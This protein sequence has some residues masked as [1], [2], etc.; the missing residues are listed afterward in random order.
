MTNSIPTFSKEQY[1]DNTVNFFKPFNVNISGTSASGTGS[2]L[3]QQ[4]GIDVQTI[5]E[6]T[7]QEGLHTNPEIN[8]LIDT[9]HDSSKYFNIFS[10]KSFGT[11]SL[12]PKNFSYENMIKLIKNDRS[13]PNNAKTFAEMSPLGAIVGGIFQGPLG[14]EAGFGAVLTG[15]TGKGH[16]SIGGFS[17]HVMKTHYQ[18]FNAVKQAYFDNMVAPGRSPD[19]NPHKIASTGFAST[20]GNFH[21]SRHPNNKFYEGNKSVLSSEDHNAHMMLKAME[22]LNKEL[23]P[24]GYRLDNQNQDNVGLAVSLPNGMGGVTEDGYFTYVSNNGYGYSKSKLHGGSELSK[25]MARK[26]GLS[27]VTV[28]TKAMTMA[29]GNKNLTVTQALQQLTRNNNN[30]N[31]SEAPNSNQA[32]TDTE[33]K[34]TKPTDEIIRA[35]EHRKNLKAH[36]QRILKKTMP[37]KTK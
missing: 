23:D 11:N 37:N 30:F 9:N 10:G 6:S 16:F 13:G 2:S 8:K 34:E 5:R 3:A 21:F 24:Q 17:E 20:I 7:V 26:L 22:A 19:F 4:T 27:D 14:G 25:S 36:L 15:P 1:T 28:L 35:S 31:T 32:S 12:F 18:N 29:R 33:N